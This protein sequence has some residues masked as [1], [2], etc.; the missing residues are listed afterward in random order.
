MNDYSNMSSF[1]T[2]INSL[3]QQLKILKDELENYLFTLKVPKINYYVSEF[4]CEIPEFNS[5]NDIT[6]FELNNLMIL[7]FNYTDTTS[8]YKKEGMDIIHI[9]GELQN[10]E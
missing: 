7:N 3:N 6:Y 9:H 10:L 5:D 2:N 1:L 8:L 4:I